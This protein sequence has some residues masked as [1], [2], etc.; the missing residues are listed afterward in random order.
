MEL[1]YLWWLCKAKLNLLV[2]KGGEGKG[3]ITVDLA[4][5]ISQG[6][7]W[8]D[9]SENAPTGNVLFI[10]G[11]DAYSDTV[12][13]PRLRVAGADMALYLLLVSGRGG[14][15]PSGS[16]RSTRTLTC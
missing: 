4:A 15:I 16:S 3:L 14:E 9:R 1:E 2:G 12:V 13:K 11:E 5:R 8:P 6:F 10:T 7:P